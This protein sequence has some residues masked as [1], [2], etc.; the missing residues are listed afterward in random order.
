MGDCSVIRSSSAVVVRGHRD[1][2]YLVI[3][4]FYNYPGTGR[5]VRTAMHLLELQRERESPS[6]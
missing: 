6:F 4:Y 5:G 1:K 2:G 3:D